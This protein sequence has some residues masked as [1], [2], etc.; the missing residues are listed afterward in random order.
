MVATDRIAVDAIDLQILSHL[1]TNARN[2]QSDIAKAVGLAPSGVLE[3]IRKLEARGAIAGYTAYIEPKILG[4]GM[5]AF[6]AVRTDEVATDNRIA[7]EV[8]AIP[9]VLEV[10]HVA[11]DDCFLVKVRARDAEHLGQLLRTRI[12]RIAGVRST[13]TTIVL[14]TV[15]ETSRLPIPRPPEAKP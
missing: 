8:A 9:E 6:V 2:T 1:Q 10:H 11:G 4:L 7:H 14:E 12:G 15:K 3:R 13:R 5:L